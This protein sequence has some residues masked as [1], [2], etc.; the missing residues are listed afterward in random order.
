MLYAALRLDRAWR[1][2]S[3]LY[4]AKYSVPGDGT[5]FCY[6]DLN[7]PDLL[8]N[9]RG[10]WTRRMR[11]IAPLYYL[12]C[13]TNLVS[14]GGESRGGGR[15][16]LDMYTASPIRYI[17]TKEDSEV[18]GVRWK[19]TPCQPG[20]LRITL[21]SIPHGATGPT[22]KLRRAMLPWFVGV[23]D[24]ESSLEVVEGGTW[25]E[26]ATAHRDFV[27]PKATPMAHSWANLVQNSFQ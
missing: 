3:Y 11:R 1:L 25:E 24:D 15:R 8:A 18:L 20:E 21:P 13:N 22:T 2:V 26:L 5:Y 27:A 16:R 6:V 9:T 10:A 19:K 7:I 14:G 23:Q 17:F 12:G 4:Y